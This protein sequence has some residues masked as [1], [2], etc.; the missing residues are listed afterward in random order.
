VFRAA[1]FGL[2]QVMDAWTIIPEQ[3]F[4]AFKFRRHVATRIA[5]RIGQFIAMGFIFLGFF[6]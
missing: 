5:A 2:A 6:F 3:E 4:L 1:Q